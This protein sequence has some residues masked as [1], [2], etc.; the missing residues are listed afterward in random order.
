VRELTLA[1]LPLED[2]LRHLAGRRAT[3]TLTAATARFRKKLFLVDG[4]LAGV[5]SDNPRELLGHFLVGWG[6]IN[7]AQLSEAM[8]LHERIGS[9][10]GRV[11]ERL[12]AIDSDRLEQALQAQVEEALYDLFLVH[13]ESQRLLENV[14]PSL[15]PLTL[16][17]QVAPLVEE[18]L[19]RRARLR[20]INEL[21]GNWS[22]VPR[23]VPGRAATGL[24]QREARVLA[25]VD[26]VRDIE[27]L[28]LACHLLPFV[29]AELVARGVREGFLSIAGGAP[30]PQPV[31][32]QEGV[33][34]AALDAG[35]LRR[36]WDAI[37]Q[38]RSSGWAAEHA[39][40]V[41]RLERR[42]GEAL[43][44]R[45]ISPELIPFP[46]EGGRPGSLLPGEAFV[47]SRVNGLW[48]LKEIGRVAP[49][50]DFEFAVIVDSLLRR[51]L[52]ELRSPT[53][54]RPSR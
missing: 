3:G 41:A 51:G 47:L 19:R 31:P 1:D 14:L 32:D 12:G 15:R 36:A 16:R 46:R 42:L 11:L 45:R 38:M 37:A 33:A 30:A 29:V 26:G 52:I 40:T 27:S 2:L 28:A 4:T 50:P 35:D 39:E 49:F 48:S 18:G 9:P 6:F 17:L 23:P 53:S 22:A 20:E 34:A 21:V 24:S 43:A 54:T 25:E 13:I 7:E 8:Q 44:G 10:L 5:A